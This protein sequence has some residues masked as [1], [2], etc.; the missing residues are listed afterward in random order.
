[1][2]RGEILVKGQVCLLVLKVL[3]TIQV[4]W[5][6]FERH[7]APQI[8]MVGYDQSAPQNYRYLLQNI[9]SF[10]VLFCERDL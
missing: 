1:M 3:F 2:H 8:R 4:I 7:Q 5:T 9:V 6:K 10:I